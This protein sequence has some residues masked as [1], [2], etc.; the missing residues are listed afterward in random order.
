MTHP[1]FESVAKRIARKKNPHTGKPYGEERARAI[2]A[3]A[4]RKASAR[5]RAENP[6]LEKVSGV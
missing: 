1:G 5:A 4:A 3:S 6:R 2:L